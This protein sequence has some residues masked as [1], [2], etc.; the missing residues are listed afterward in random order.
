MKTVELK[1]KFNWLIW[2]AATLVIFILLG[3]WGL[4]PT[5][6]G[7]PRSLFEFIRSI[8]FYDMSWDTC[9]RGLKVI[10]SLTAV[11]LAVSAALGWD[12]AAIVSTSL[13]HLRQSANRKA[14]AQNTQLR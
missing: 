3:Q 10:L 11:Y 13:A 7:R 12:I 8:I 1:V 4:L 6:W 9:T 14:A 5:K 2:M